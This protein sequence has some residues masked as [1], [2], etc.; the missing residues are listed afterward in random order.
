LG[1]SLCV[2]PNLQ[3][4]T[5]QLG[6]QQIIQLLRIGFAGSRFHGLADKEA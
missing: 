5:V 6:L 1:A 4:L 3:S 2:A